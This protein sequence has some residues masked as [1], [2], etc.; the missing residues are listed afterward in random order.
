MGF[1][2]VLHGIKP[3]PAATSPRQGRG[4][5]QRRRRCHGKKEVLFPSPA[6][7]AS[8]AAAQ[9]AV[10]QPRLPAW[11][12][13]VQTGVLGW[14]ALYCHPL[15]QQPLTLNIF[16]GKVVAQGRMVHWQGGAAPHGGRKGFAFANQI[17]ALQYL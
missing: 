3:L 2:H 10:A 7:R 11:S 1:Q 6:N 8:R 15:L 16:H 9:A 14:G 13:L 12:A 17:R 5:R 4:M